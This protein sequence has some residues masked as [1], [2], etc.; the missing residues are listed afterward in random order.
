MSG[1][2]YRAVAVNAI[3]GVPSSGATLTVSGFAPGFTASPANQTVVAGGNVV[4]TA[5]ASGYPS[6]TYKWQISINHGSTWTNL[7]DGGA[8]SGSATAALAINGVAMAMNGYEYQVIASNSVLPSG[9]TSAAATLTVAT[10]PVFSY[11]PSNQVQNA[12]GNVALTAGVSGNPTPTLQ[13]QVSTD[14]G[15]TFSAVANGAVYSGVTTSSLL[16]TRV[17]AVMGGYKYR[18]VATNASLRPAEWPAPPPRSR[19]TR[20]PFSA[21]SPRIRRFQ[22]EAAPPSRSPPPADPA[23]TYYWQYSA[24][25]GPVSWINLSNGGVYSGVTTASLT[26]TGATAGSERKSF[27][28]RWR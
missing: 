27:T 24:S 2:L 1:N 10:I 17:T 16:I 7:T 6:P 28:A 23:P 11:S 8:Y 13:W 19:S 12:G 3:G 4:L 15:G 5:A 22:P 25:G 26:I 14:G 9:V 18:L 21:P 20:C